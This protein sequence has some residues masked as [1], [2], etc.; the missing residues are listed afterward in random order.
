MVRLNISLTVPASIGAA[1]NGPDGVTGYDRVAGKHAVIKGG[2][3]TALTTASPIPQQPQQP[4]VARLASYTGITRTNEVVGDDWIANAPAIVINGNDERLNIPG[5]YPEND[6]V[7]A[8][9]HPYMAHFPDGFRGK[10]Y[11]LAISPYPGTNDQLENPV[12]Y[13]SNDR[14]NWTLLPSPAM[15]IASPADY[16]GTQNYC[17]DNFFAFDPRN[18]EL[19]LGWRRH[20]TKGAD[21]DGHTEI[22]QYITSKDGVN[23]SGHKKLLGKMFKLEDLA[24]SP[25]LLFNPVDNMWYLYSSKEQVWNV[26]K[27]PSIENP[28]WSAAEDTGARG[29]HGE[30]RVFGEDIFMFTTYGRYN[31]GFNVWRSYGG[32]W[33]A[34]TK[35]RDNL[36]DLAPFTAAFP[37]AGQAYKSTFSPVRDGAKIQLNAIIAV[38]GQGGEFWVYSKQL[39]QAD[40]GITAARDPATVVAPTLG[41]PTISGAVKLGSK[42]TAASGAVTGDPAPSLRYQWF[43]GEDFVVGAQANTYTLVA[44]DT[45]QPVTVRES[46]SNAKGIVS[47]VS[48]PV[49]LKPE[50]IDYNTAAMA[51]YEKGM[52][53]IGTDDAVTGLALRG[54]AGITMGAAGTGASIKNSPAGITMSFGQYLT[55]GGLANLPMGDGIFIVVKLNVKEAPP[56]GTQFYVSATGKYPKLMSFSPGTSFTVQAN[57]DINYNNSQEIPAIYGSSVVLGGS[58]DEITKVLLSLNT[59]G[60]TQ[61]RAITLTDPS[62]SALTLMQQVSGT[63]E[64]LALVGRPQGGAWPV[65]FNAVVADF[66]A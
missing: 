19:I 31:P 41:K 54:T 33:H 16:P 15:P 59:D 20:F 23:W 40:L 21:Q 11:L 64:R 9:V 7:N 24:V 25:S 50:A 39:P 8:F 57:A 18:K 22:M 1:T 51:Y 34:L 32:D 2:V 46:A 27:T 14:Q 63:L 29:W 37:G 3:W 13:Q 10:Q 52:P 26:R 61:S 58:M 56:T 35:V 17:S 30:V 12:L 53:I 48:S 4:Q 36:L 65:T 47:A 5:F 6:A 62:I 38:R 42:L 44:A 60:S 43:R 45:N 55:K 28:V 49:V 66:R